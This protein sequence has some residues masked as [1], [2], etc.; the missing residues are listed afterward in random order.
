M[1]L[2]SILKL[3]G[4][5]VITA[6]GGQGGIGSGSK[7][8]RGGAIINGIVIDGDDP[9]YEQKIKQAWRNEYDTD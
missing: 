2:T 9:D 1:M 7:R 4:I 3:F 8:G 5:R 6:K